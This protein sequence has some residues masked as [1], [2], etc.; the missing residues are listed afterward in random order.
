MSANSEYPDAS[1]TDAPHRGWT[2]LQRREGQAVLQWLHGEQRLRNG[3]VA[4]A[5]ALRATLSEHVRTASEA[6][7]VCDAVPAVLERCDDPDTYKMRSAGIAYAWL[8]LLDR[9]AR[10][11]LGL[12]YLLLQGLL[13]MG[14][15]G[16]RVLDVGTGPGPSAFAT[17]DFYA[18]LENYAPGADASDWQQ[19]SDITCVECAPS[20]NRIRHFLAEHLFRARAK[21]TS[22]FRY[23]GSMV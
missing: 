12:E 16:V 2:D 14:R 11:W 9:Y 10:T 21:I 15:Y 7:A 4:L 22:V 18:A 1:T 17:H 23:M 5:T 19:P 20:M 8:H 3:F 6:R 13:P